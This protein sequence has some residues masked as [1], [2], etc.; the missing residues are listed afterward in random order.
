MSAPRGDTVLRLD[1]VRV[2]RMAWARR[3]G[4]LRLHLAVGVVAVGIAFALPR[5]YTAGVTLVPAP[6]EGLQVD[7][8]GAS[9]GTMPTLSGGLGFGPT[10][11]DQLRMV[12]QSRAVA[13]SIIGSFG[14]VTRWKLDRR[15]QAREKLA[16]HVTVVTPKEGQV[17][18]SVEAESPVLAR[19]MAAAYATFARTEAVRLKT[20]L[21]TQRRAYLETRLADIEH[22]IA[23]SGDR[24]RAFEEKHGVIALP[25][26]TG[27]ALAALGTLRAQVTGLEAEIA[28]ARRFYT[29]N[30]PE[31]A[32]LVA[33]RAEMERQLAAMARQ[34]ATFATPGAGLPALTQQY[35]TLTRELQGLMTVS[36]ILRRMVEQARVEE[37]SPVAA[38][39][40]LDQAE[41]PERHSRPQRGLLVALALVLTAAMSLGWFA[42]QDAHGRGDT[43]VPAFP[44][45]RG[46]TEDAT[47]GIAA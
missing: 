10:P 45:R 8:T 9:V 29:D 25:E 39:S 6:R 33:R 27:Q 20:S 38:F 7:F 24:L 34:G 16:E 41:L 35:V 31:V 12:V 47:H 13:D 43:T 28:G 44:F 23:V 3:R 18:I 4:L 21:A 32:T 2:A 36:E 1:L 30:S 42:W 11:Q 5:W 37:S 26:Q 17:H 19:D 22:D 14:L 15:E 46:E 40:V